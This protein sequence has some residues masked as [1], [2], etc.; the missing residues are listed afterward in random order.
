MKIRTK[1]YSAGNFYFID[2]QLQAVTNYSCIPWLV[3]MNIGELSLVIGLKVAITLRPLSYL[4]FVLNSYSRQVYI[5]QHSSD[6]GLTI[7]F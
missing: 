2:V 7:G 6:I 3:F 4:S 5:Q 1:P